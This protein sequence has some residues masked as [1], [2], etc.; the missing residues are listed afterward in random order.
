MHGYFFFSIVDKY[1]I[2]NDEL[3]NNLKSV[4]NPINAFRMIKRLS[5]AWR[6]LEEKM[7][8]DVSEEFLHNL[9]TSG[10]TLLPSDVS[11]FFGFFT[12]FV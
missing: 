11:D 3:Q 7:K 1:K 12:F 10:N 4:S 5:N 8:S 2:N 9:T 6:E